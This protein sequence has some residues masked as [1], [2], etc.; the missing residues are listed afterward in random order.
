MFWEDD[1]QLDTQQYENLKQEYIKRKMA[2]QDQKNIEEMSSNGG[3][4]KHSEA[5]F[6][7]DQTANKGVLGRAMD[8]M[9]AG[10]N[11]DNERPPTFHGEV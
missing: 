9:F 5:N 11:I 2:K 8:F 7:D 4:T 1:E 6:Y 10:N 3:S